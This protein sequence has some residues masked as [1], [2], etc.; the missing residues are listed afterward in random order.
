MD[1]QKLY[2][3]TVKYYS[4]IKKNEVLIHVTTWMSPENLLLNERSQIQK[5]ICCMI[6]F[7]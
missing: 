2:I 5:A 4:V 3:H 7:I 6:P 1:K